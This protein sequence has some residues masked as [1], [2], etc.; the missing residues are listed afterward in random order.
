MSSKLNFNSKTYVKMLHDS[1]ELLQY[2][3]NWLQSI[4]YAL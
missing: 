3:V 4:V 2:E 1:F